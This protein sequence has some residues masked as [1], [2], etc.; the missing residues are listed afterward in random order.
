M[1]QKLKKIIKSFLFCFV[2]ILSSCEKE[3]VGTVQKAEAKNNISIKYI[4]GKK[5]PNIISI[6]NPNY[7]SRLKSISSKSNMITDSFGN[8]SVENILEVIDSL[9]NKNYSFTLTP[10]KPK[11][12]SIFNLVINSNKDMAIVE[13]R[14]APNFAQEYY[15]GTKSMSE[16][17]GNILKFPYKAVSNLLYKTSYTCVQNIDEIVN[18]DEIIVN[19]GNVVGSGSGGGTTTINDTNTYTGGDGGTVALNYGGSYSYWVCNKWGAHHTG[20][21]SECTDPAEGGTWVIILHPASNT[22]KF[23]NPKSKTSGTSCCD[24]T[25]LVGSIGVNLF[26]LAVNIRDIMGFSPKSQQS[27][28][29]TSNATIEQTA[30]LSNFLYENNNST[31]AINFS[32]ELTTQMMLN[33]GLILDADTSFKSPANIDRSSITNATKEGEKFNLVYDEL[34]KSPK[35]KELFLDLFQDNSRFNVKFEIGNVSNGANGNTNTDLNNP[36]LNKI[37][38]SPT[39]LNNS[40]KME[41]AKTIIHECIHAYLNV[42]L[43]DAGQGISIPTLNNLDFFNVVNQKY[44][45]FNGSQ[46]QHNFIY[47]YMLPTLQTI[48]AQVKD[49]LVTPTNNLEMLNDVVVHIPNNNSPATPFVWADYYHNLSLNGLQNCSFFQ[50]EI[51]S[52]QVVNG[53]LT[54]LITIDQTLMQSFIQYIRVGQFNIYP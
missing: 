52:V 35:F 30:T 48:L 24:D 26:N 32:K 46:E 22:S 42:K 37:T 6:I 21:P 8:I 39:F 2:V 19:G 10:K 23:S 51:G 11:P 41:I 50:N 40:N 38:I 28:W 43:C 45:G 31:E 47:N 13:Y 33:S 53:V 16:F 25:N 44:N 54:P 29:L 7:S 18:C 9:G 12:N 36:T 14:M 49:T 3:G 15:N 34:T 1:N 27:L 20:G 5:I 17:T 4:S